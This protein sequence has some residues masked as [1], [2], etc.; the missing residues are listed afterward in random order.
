MPGR[1]TAFSYPVGW[2][3]KRANAGRKRVGKRRVAHLRRPEHKARFPLH[4]VM[5]LAPGCRANLRRRDLYRML[6][7]AFCR[8]CNGNGFRIVSY[9]IQGNHVHLICE[10]RDRRALSKGMQGFNT[11]MA[12]G[13][14]AVLGRSGRVFDDRY[15]AE[16]LRNPNRVRNT[17]CYVLNNAKRHAREV[18]EAAWLER[19]WVDPYT[20]AAHF[21]GW[22][23]DCRHWVPPPH[24][25]AP[26][27]ADAE[28]WLLREGWRRR[29]LIDTAEVP[30]PRRAG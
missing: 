30:G 16:P 19:S 15:F 2:G 9:S 13:I 11:R 28:T 5:R 6:Y 25:G 7:R 23:S 17:L 26:P 24:D 8:G 3:G 14:N 20:S 21:D 22:R 1:Q 4:V 18:G 10:A 27:V 12:K 29:G